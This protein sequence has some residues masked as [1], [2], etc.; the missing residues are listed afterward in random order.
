MYK[1]LKIRIM[2]FIIFLLFTFPKIIN[3]SNLIG[4]VNLDGKITITDLSVLKNYLIRNEIE[5]IKEADINGDNKITITDLSHLK[6]I[7]VSGTKEEIDGEISIKPSETNWTRNDISVE[8]IYPE[9]SNENKKQYSEDGYIWNDYIEEI[10]IGK[11]STIYARIINKYGDILKENSI[12]INNID[13]KAPKE[14]ELEIVDKT[15]KS[16]TVKA[17]TEDAEV[18]NRDGKSGIAGYYYTIDNGKTLVTNNEKNTLNYQFTNLL[19]NT[20]YTIKAIAVDNAGNTK[21]SS[22]LVVKTEEGKIDTLYEADADIIKETWSSNDGRTFYLRALT[23]TGERLPYF[24]WSNIM[25]QEKED[26]TIQRGIPE[27]ETLEIYMPEII[28]QPNEYDRINL[29]FEYLWSNKD[30]KDYNL[31]DTNSFEVY[32]SV[33]DS[34]YYGP[35]EL[36]YSMVIDSMKDGTTANTVATLYRCITKDLNIPK[37]DKEQKIKIK[38]NPYTNL[39]YGGLFRVTTASIKG[40]ED[41]RILNQ[42]KEGNNYIKVNSDILRDVAARHMAEKL[43]QIRWT[44][45]ETIESKIPEYGHDEVRIFLTYNN[46]TEYYGLPYAQPTDSSYEQF[47]SA[48]DNSIYTGPF[49][50][51]ELYSVDC[52]SSISDSLTRIMPMKF[53]TAPIQLALTKYSE[54]LGDLKYSTVS[55]GEMKKINNEQKIYKAYALLKKGD[56]I[57]TNPYGMHVRMITGETHVEYIDETKTEINPSKSYVITTEISGRNPNVATSES[58]GDQIEGI[59]TSWRVNRKYTF[60]QLYNHTVDGQD[61][62]YIPVTFKCYKEGK[63]E[64]LDA[65]IINPNNAEN[66]KDGLK[67]VIDSNYRIN[68][69]IY[70]IKDYNNS[71]NNKKYIDY[72]KESVYSLYFESN[73]KINETIKT[74]E[75][76][77]YN[78]TIMVDTGSEIEQIKEQEILNLDFEI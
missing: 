1:K 65:K 75:T 77:Q 26:G 62:M 3:A 18:T 39:N 52:T 31:E 36:E 28:I 61:A 57:I 32:V 4:D 56:I 37:S 72:T 25:Y 78:I 46:T 16:I 49:E 68:Q 64:K 53:I 33:N 73:K 41:E 38:I 24:A 66:I 47:L 9:C 15:A 54:I 19:P 70:A 21:T 60:E 76:G 17:E 34:K 5:Y 51:E 40:Y 22:E 6:I 30:V 2:I 35:I 63:T 29:E 44:P 43:S 10:I 23:E 14:F 20:E 71:E 59:Y 12:E 7:L 27:G 48:V 13:K 58:Q 74:L 69:I 45:T 11:N 67:G 8:I 55:T 42:Y 50:Y